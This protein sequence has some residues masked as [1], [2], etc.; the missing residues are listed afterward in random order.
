MHL[1]RLFLMAWLALAIASLCFLFW[2]C[3]QTGMIAKE[4]SK[5]ISLSP[6]RAEL[7]TDT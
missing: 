1:L 2:L 6:K 3:K 5:L 7:S 4:P